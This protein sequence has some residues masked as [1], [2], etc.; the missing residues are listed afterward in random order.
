MCDLPTRKS[1]DKRILA[2]EPQFEKWEKVKDCADQFID[3][4]LNY[5]QSGHPG[6]SRSKVHA[7]VATLLGGFMRWDIRHPEKAF[8][9][10]FILVA[11]HTVPL[12]YGTFPVFFEAL[13][14]KHEKTGDDR[15]LVP[16]AEERALYWEDLVHFRRNKGLPG[17]AE[18]EGKTLFLKFNTGPSGH[19]S[20]AA[21]GRGVR[22]EAGRSG[23]RQGVRVRRR[24]RAHAR[25][26]AR[27]D[28]LRVGTRP[29]QSLSTSSTGTTTGSIPAQYSSVIDKTPRD[30]FGA[31]GWRVCEAEDG[32]DWESVTRA[33]VDLVGGE[34]PEKR[35][36]VMYMK[37]R[38]GRGYL[39]YDY[40]SHG[41][42]HKMNSDLFWQ[43]KLPFMEKYGVR[44]QGYGEP[45]PDDP[46]ALVEQM[47]ANLKIVADVIRADEALVDYLADTLV[48]MGESVPDR[49]PSFK[50]DVSRNPLDDPT[51][52][53]FRE[54]PEGA[55][56][57]ARREETQPG[58]ARDV[59]IV[60]E[61]VVP[62]GV[63][64]SSLHSD[65]RRSR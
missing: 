17:H 58:G 63:R 13:R 54:L 8:S 28:E 60:G 65:E 4:M 1:S 56:R 34:N 53:R 35:P 64:P 2:L 62:Q 23:R 16:N 7:F 9:D 5:R 33:L 45:A 46:A 31:H 42:P 47:R 24:R 30:W 44:F 29:V 14:A 22:A 40:A 6:G 50:L 37:T 39:K 48:S 26:R 55:L 21:A 61:R 10:R 38:K 51:A 52:L 12:I 25:R 57:T 49:I 32:S 18:M 27:N 59:R 41:S 19:G 43:T 36:N 11:G 20:P 3:I 15:Y